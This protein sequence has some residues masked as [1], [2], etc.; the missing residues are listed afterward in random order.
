MILKTLH[1]SN[2]RNYSKQEFSFSEQLTVIVGPNTAGKTTILEAIMLLSTGSSFR[3]ERELEMIRMGEEVA[4][5]KAVGPLDTVEVVLTPGSVLG[6]KTPYKKFTL[7]KI[8][9]RKSEIIGNL[10]A[11]LFW[12]ED[13]YL[14]IGSP[15]GRRH[16]LDTV[17]SQASHAYYRSLTAYEKALRVR[18]KLLSLIKEHIAVKPDELFYWEKQLIDQGAAIHNVRASYISSLNSFV[19]QEK[20]GIQFNALYDHSI[21]SKE[22]FQTYYDAERASGMTLVGPHRDDFVVYKGDCP[23]ETKHLKK[24]GSRGEQR[25]GVLWLKLAEL[26]YLEQSLT[27]KPLLLLDDILSEL[28]TH[29]KKL[30]FVGIHNQQTIITTADSSALPDSI[31]EKAKV[32]TLTSD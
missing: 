13:L 27:I 12:P 17:L 29:H 23:D 21:V 7:N 3:A 11:V 30:V 25:M 1:L 10:P 5:V 20:R 2:F 8:A 32:I 6:K 28:D 26:S 31:L 16:Y 14:I 18:N 19:L 4:R 24:F 22:R 15:S 9:R